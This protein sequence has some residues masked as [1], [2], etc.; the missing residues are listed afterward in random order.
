MRGSAAKARVNLEAKARELRYRF[1]RSLIDARKADC[2]AVGHTAE[3]SRCHQL[4][5]EG[6]GG[7]STVAVM[8]DM[9]RR[10]ELGTATLMANVLMSRLVRL[11]SRCV[12]KSF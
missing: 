6:G 12:A 7:R 11:T 10:P 3:I 4:R 5:V 2:I 8:P 9:S 1:F